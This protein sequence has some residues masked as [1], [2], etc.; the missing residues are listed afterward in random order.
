MD[1]EKDE[2]SFRYEYAISALL[3]DTCAETED[4][5]LDQATR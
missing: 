2:L 5:D 4:L 1:E 3:K